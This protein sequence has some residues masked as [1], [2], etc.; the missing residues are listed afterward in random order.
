MR[1]LDPREARQWSE[2]SGVRLD[3]NEPPTAA[4]SAPRVSARFAIPASPRLPWFAGWLVVTV[5]GIDERLLWVT[6]TGIW[7]SSENW[8]L[9]NGLRRG[10]GEARGIDQVPAVVASATEIEDLAAFVLVALVSG[11]DAELYGTQDLVRVIISHD[12]WVEFSSEDQ[13]IIEQII[14]EL[15]SADIQRGPSRAV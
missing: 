8:A 14:A 1:F 11:W 10:Y 4:P 9:I 15:A 2:R 13:G 7:E 12:E 6:E 3:A 5:P